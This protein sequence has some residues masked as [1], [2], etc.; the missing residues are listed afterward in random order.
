MKGCRE[1]DGLVD[2]EVTTVNCGRW[3]CCVRGMSKVNS[4]KDCHV[5]QH[6]HIAYVAW[7]GVEENLVII[8]SQIL[9]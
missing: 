5:S 3:C 4:I 1:L 2:I 8:I 6:I 7:M 9:S